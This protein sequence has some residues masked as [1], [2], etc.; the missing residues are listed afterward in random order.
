MKNKNI[1][2]IGSKGIPAK[3]GGFET[4]VERLVERKK[5]NEIQYHI[6]CMGNEEKDFTYH[7]ARCFQVKVPNIGPAKAV[8]Y[9]LLALQKSIAYIK[10]NK[11]ENAIVYILACRI[12][13]FAW[14]YKNKM[15]RLHCELYVN[16]DGH[17]WLRGKWNWAIKKYWKISEKYMIKNADLIICD[18]INIEQYIMTEY[19]KFKPNTTY[20][21]YGADLPE[22][23][24]ESNH[25]EVKEWLAER[26]LAED[27]YYLVVGRF[28]PENNYE[29]M[30]R[31]FMATD[32]K[33]KLVM[34]TNLE[35]NKFY[36]KLQNHTNFNK[37]DRVLFAGTVYN[38]ELLLS[39][40][41]MAF[42]YIHGHE[43]GGTNPSLLEAL[44]STQLNL[45][46]DVGFNR[47]V[48]EDGAFYWNK[49]DGSLKRL[50]TIVEDFEKEEI[51]KIAER[52]KDRIAKKYSW[53][54]IVG[55]YE[56]LFL[57]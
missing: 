50:I 19:K 53:E 21:S 2:I 6:A 9:D 36:E 51:E 28:V 14:Y 52:A 1:F 15:R 17:E 48:A 38:Q 13:P 57:R 23:L 46:L 40:R 18:S 32:T 35:K 26:E 31:E 45:L 30:I 47:E 11:I 16:P 37:D 39:I 41:K 7:K 12:G 54:K 5:R 20:I 24:T 44:A 42:G 8:L 34:I 56:K 43:V 29:A 27:E 22:V 49:K 4:F 25:V 55:E 10:Q 33:K 3:Y